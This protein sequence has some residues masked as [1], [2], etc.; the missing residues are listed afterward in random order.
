MLRRLFLHKKML[1]GSV[2]VMAVILL[3]SALADGAV[4]QTQEYQITASSVWERYPTIGKD[5]ISDLV[6]YTSHPVTPSGFGP[7]DIW[8][9]R[10]GANG[11]PTGPARQVTFDL[12]DDQLNDVSG[13]YIVYTAYESTSSVRGMI[14]LY[15]ISTYEFQ[16]LGYAEVVQEPKIHGSIVVWVQGPSTAQTVMMYDLAWLGT[17]HDPETLAGPVPS[18]DAPQVGDRFVVWAEYTG[19]QY[20]VF[21]YDLLAQTKMVVTYTA[22]VNE[23]DPATSGEWIVWQE[24]GETLTPSKIVARNL[25]ICSEAFVVADNGALNE[26][27]S[28]SGDLITWESNLSGNKD[29]YVYRLSTGETFQVTTNPN[30]QYLNDVWQTGPS[31]GLVAYVDLRNGNEN[32]FVSKLTF[33]NAPVANA[34]ADQTV[35]HAILVTLDGSGS[36]DPDENY[37]L[38]YAWEIT[39]MP[40]GSSVTLSNP[41]T[42]N[43]SFIPDVPGDYTIQLIVTDA[44]NLA[45]APDTVIVSTS[46]T[47]PVAEAGPDQS[48]TMVGSTV[49]LDGTQSYDDDGD[50]F[51]FL[52]TI[53]QK[54]A[55]SNANLSNPTSDTPTFKAD[56]QGDYI[57]SLVVT[58]EFG[59]VSQP[60]T[61]TISFANVKPIADAGGN[62]SVVVGNTV[63][64][65]G[66]GS[67]DA[68]ND[69]LSYQWSIVTRP[70]GSS[71]TLSS[72]TSVQTSFTADKP[73][74]YIISL[75][76]NDGFDNSDPN[77]VT[78]TATSTSNQVIDVLNQIITTVNG[79]PAEVFKN[80]NMRNAL[81]NKINAVINLIEQG[82]YI[83]A[84]DKLQND[85]LQKTDGCATD[86]VPDKNDWITNCT[87]Q[88][89]VYPLIIEAIQL[90]GG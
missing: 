45:S 48:I 59:A 81:T 72:S 89:Q 40:D 33:N 84:L 36:S 43:P 32:I 83:D 11:A 52:W 78:V 46:N 53:S 79:L 63:T 19:G 37:P 2:A 75:V 7:G 35:N 31:S 87:A 60:D 65:D 58:D 18:A 88:G 62:Q 47:A 67:S 74:D 50:L 73:G 22:D 23:V 26:R 61:V 69:P 86:G 38:T 9:Q 49:Y 80:L 56:V 21:A 57:I 28:I 39:S 1:S 10:L 17:D 6:V 55:R 8:Y 13:D 5:S 76:V 66:S 77:N 90:L 3:T 64:L 44:L 14:V 30:N 82:L 34:G 4:L 51:T 15:R 27:P 24:F 20:N 71:A 42:V 85:I 16:P 54:P 12:T 70:A 29:I 68:N 25:V 41:N